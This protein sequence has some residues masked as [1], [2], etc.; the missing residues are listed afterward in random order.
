MNIVLC[1][2]H[3]TNQHSYN[4]FGNDRAI[5]VIET[6]M[7]FSNH[8]NPQILNLEKEKTEKGTT[9]I[10][11]VGK[12]AN[13]AGWGDMAPSVARNSVTF[14][15]LQRKTKNKKAVDKVC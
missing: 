7:D 11:R 15:L 1:Q 2:V 6:S 3:K 14:E 13:K 10:L 4:K 12:A 5:C 8:D 9:L